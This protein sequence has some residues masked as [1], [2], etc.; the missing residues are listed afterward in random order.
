[1]DF[2]RR[3]LPCSPLSPA[4]LTVEDVAAGIKSRHRKSAKGLDGV[5]LLDLKSLPPSGLQALCDMFQS[6]ENHGAWP[7]E[8]LDARIT[9]LAKCDEPRT[10]MDFRPICIFSLVYRLWGSHHAKWLIR[11]LDTVLPDTLFGSRPGFH[12]GMVW[13]QLLSQIELAH[14]FGLS[15]CGVTAD[16][17]KAFVHLPRLVIFES[18]LLLGLPVTI[19]RAWAAA[20]GSMGRR[21]PLRE[22][23]SDPVFS[24]T[25]FAEGDGL[26]CLAMII[27]D[28]LLHRWIESTQPSPQARVLSYVDDLQLVTYDPSALDSVLDSLKTFSKAADLLLD[29]RK[30]FVWCADADGRRYLRSRGHQVAP[31]FKYLGA[32]IQVTKQHTNGTLKARVD[33]LVDVWDK[34]RL[35]ASPYH[36][37]LRAI[38]TAAWPGGL[39]G[40]AATLL[41]SEVFNTLRASAM[42]ALRADG[43]GCSSI[44]HFGCVETPDHDPLYWA[45]LSSLRAA[46]DCGSLLSLSPNCR[47]R[48]VLFVRP[49]L[50]VSQAPFRK[51]SNFWDGMSLT[52]VPSVTIWANFRFSVCRLTN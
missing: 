21:F 35:S 2:A 41:G 48:P 10:V 17:Q 13:T 26:S 5:S 45:I 46:R 16:V 38:R 29:N 20:V 51:G 40:V 32:H 1:M 44:L 4:P 33:S 31:Q 49:R 11:S 28:L 50:L 9:S 25:G 22:S 8:I 7:N 47:F 39:H 12:A 42:R 23:L 36:L 24:C 34:L 15:L 18:C 37:K 3:I 6:A 19:V 52:R 43:S 14:Q 27:I 30:T